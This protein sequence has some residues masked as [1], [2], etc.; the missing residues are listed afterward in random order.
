[1]VQRVQAMTITIMVID[2]EYL[3]L[4]YVY[5]GLRL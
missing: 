3:R 5:C 1:M 2:V 4:K